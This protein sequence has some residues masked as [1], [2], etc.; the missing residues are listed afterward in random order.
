[1]W[2]LSPLESGGVTHYLL[3][4]KEYVVGRKNC[5]VILHNDQSVSRAHALLTVKDQALTL[6]DSSKY[7]TFVNDERLSGDTPRTLK[8][9]DRLTF[10]VFHSKFSV[11]QEVVVVCSSCLN[12]E[13]KASLTEALQH[14]G[15]RLVNTW[16][17]E[18]T[19]L[20]MPTVKVTVKT[21][22]ALLCCRPMV[23][24]EFFTEFSKA[25]QQKQPPPK[26]GSFLPEIDE[27]S[28][29]KDEVDLS[30]RPERKQLFTG[31]TFF[32]LNSR[33]LKRLSLAVSC[34]GGRSQLLEEGS[35]EVALLV[36]PSSCVIDVA[37]GNSQ[38]S[39]P[40]STKDWADSVGKI[41]QRKGL[42]F[43]T[44]SEIGLAAIYVSCNKYCNPSNQMAGSASLKMKPIIPSATLSQNAIVDETV[45]PTSSQNIT[46][47]A[48]NTEPSQ[49]V[50]GLNMTEVS[51]VGETPEKDQCRTSFDRPKPSSS[52]EL[53]GTF[54]VAETMMSSCSATD[55]AGGS[56]RKKTE[57]RQP[58]GGNGEAATR[59]LAP[60]PRTKGGGQTASAQK[61]FAHKQASQ[62]CSPQKQ[63]AMTSFF[64]PVA[65]KRPREGEESPPVQSEAK[66]SRRDE[67]DALKQT[68]DSHHKEIPN[69]SQ[70]FAPSN[71]T[72][73][74]GSAATLFPGPSEALSEG[75][76]SRKRKEMEEDA[77]GG[78]ISEIDLDELES[79]MSEDMDESDEPMSDSQGQQS[80]PTEQ[81]STNK[82][83]RVDETEPIPANH[84]PNLDS[85]AGLSANKRPQ[86]KPI[87]D[88]KAEA[89]SFIEAEPV[90]NVT[91]GHLEE[92][93][94]TEP[95]KQEAPGPGDD[96]LPS[97]LLVVEFKSLTVAAPARTKRGPAD[98]HGN[99]IRKDFKRFRKVPV[100]GAQGLPRIIG[101][102]D[103]LAHCRGRNS[104]LEE[105][106]R[107]VDE[108]D[109]QSKRE[110][111][112]GDDLF[113]YNPKP[114]KR[115]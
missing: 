93:K 44:E 98:T 2:I 68:S 72:T 23:T 11:R 18:C 84:R 81:S 106:L 76:Q 50:S 29:N 28:L 55:T 16:T 88:L 111:S 54:A 78:E 67:V 110:D 103:L 43:I 57:T 14:L 47:Y 105:W 83:K 38:A 19:Y 13:G 21:I 82:K 25:L 99:I 1:M 96:S 62:N 48:V 41:L 9:G 65:K 15:G 10:G 113:R 97:R 45:L 90:N 27:P 34:G 4:G 112:V 60:A 8:T 53:A 107:D 35:L 40:S 26:P 77:K 7:G 17:Q 94:P 85:E 104:E 42:R 95:F 5:E 71:K 109:R 87:A 69:I 115:R 61:S 64:Q 63:S 3:P 46:A 32:F 91:S 89:V 74:K 80:R 30:E 70:T 49:G 114:T 33:Q 86:A 37:A 100:P 52:A 51:A 66:L 102:S 39:L 73:T 58:V 101:G 22:C 108:E 92:S 79:I 6:K 31:K 59:F 56:E 12:N 24:Q 20:V 36:S 75:V